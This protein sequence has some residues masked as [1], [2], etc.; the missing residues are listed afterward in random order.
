LIAYTGNVA[1]GGPIEWK[2]EDKQ[3]FQQV[4]A[5]SG[6]K[7]RAKCFNLDKKAADVNLNAFWIEE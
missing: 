6:N 1:G 4:G 7:F 2:A 5:A 3:N